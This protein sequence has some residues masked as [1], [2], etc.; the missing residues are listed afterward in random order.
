MFN[1]PLNVLNAT[2]N[3]REYLGR[4]LNR[5]RMGTSNSIVL[6]YCKSG[7]LLVIVERS[8]KSPGA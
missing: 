7:V 1:E 4:I 3:Y 8:Y 2:I 6:I 5:L